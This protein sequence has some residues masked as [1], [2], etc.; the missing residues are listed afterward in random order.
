MLEL[1]PPDAILR[2]RIAPDAM[3]RVPEYPIGSTVGVWFE[4]IDQITE[5]RIDAIGIAA[6]FRRPELSDYE[7]QEEPAEIER[8]AAGLWR[9]SAR[10]MMPGPWL[11][12]A[13]SLG[14]QPVTATQVVRCV[15][16]DVK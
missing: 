5:A 2:A 3:L 6:I 11:F 8:R 10:L 12:W 9:V 1:V 13:M 16:G 15:Y 4:L 7:H 14:P